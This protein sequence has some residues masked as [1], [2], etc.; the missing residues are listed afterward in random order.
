LICRAARSD[1][2]PCPTGRALAIT[3]P[4]LRQSYAVIIAA[5]SGNA[6]RLQNAAVAVLITDPDRAPTPQN[7]ERL[8]LQFGL[9]PA[10][11]RVAAIL[12]QGNSAERL[13][14]PCRFPWPPCGLISEV[15][16]A[17]PQRNGNLN[18]CGFC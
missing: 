7:A 17:K 13:P 3:R 15:C 1:A 16:S 11:G 8:A 12:A 6:S 5:L 14:R 4:S 9:T 10:E 18:S 2:L